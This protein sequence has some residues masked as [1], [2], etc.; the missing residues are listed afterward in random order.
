M[1]KL[2]QIIAIYQ[3]VIQEAELALQDARKRI[4]YISLLRLI[5]FVGAIAG[6]IVFWSDGWLYISVFAALPFILFIWL[7]KRHNFCFFF[8]GRIF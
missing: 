8:N 5:L 3:Q 4:Y 2:E 6:A 7:V 1:E